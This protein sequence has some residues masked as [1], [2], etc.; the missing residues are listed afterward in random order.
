M[1][2]TTAAPAEPLPSPIERPTVLDTGLPA[3]ARRSDPIVRRHLGV[4][5]KTMGFDWRQF[6][7]PIAVQAVFILFSWPLPFLL[8][9]IMPAVT[10]SLVALPVAAYLHATALIAIATMTAAS[11]ADERR[12]DSLDLLRLCP[13]PLR[14]IVYSKIAAA[15]WRQAENYTLILAAVAWCS[16]PLLVVLSDVLFAADAHPLLMRAAIIAALIVSI[17]RPLL[18]AVAIGAIGAMCGA[19]TRWRLSAGAS[20]AVLGIAYFAFING[21]RLVAW[22][23]LERALVEFALPLLAP[24]VVIGLC[25]RAAAFLLAREP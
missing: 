5:W 21:V 25:T 10:L 12:N 4:Y 24:V 14:H 8:S 16:L 13:R 20:A 2:R 19:A 18:E 22:P 3:W 15:V 7:R 9:I 6:A 1:L 17:V 11:V 23:P